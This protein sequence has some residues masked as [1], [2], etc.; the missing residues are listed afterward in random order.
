MKRRMVESCKQPTMVIILFLSL[1]LSTRAKPS[2]PNVLFIAV[3]DLKPSIGAFGDALAITPNLDQLAE[4]G[5]VFLNNHCQKAICGPSRA[6]LMSGMRPDTIRVWEFGQRMREINP[7]LLS[8]P[9]HFKNHGYVTTAIGK[10]YDPRNVNDQWDE[11]SWSIPHKSWSDFR[12][13]PAYRDV[14]NGQHH[15][16]RAKAVSAEAKAKGVVGYQAMRKYLFEEDVWAVTECLAEN[17]PDHAYVDGAI[18]LRAVEMLKELGASDTPFFLGVGFAKPHL[19]FVAPKKYWDLYDREKLRIHPFQT[20]SRYAVDM[21]YHTSG[22]LKSYSGIPSEMN[23]YADDPEKWLSEQK[24]L[25]LIHGYYACA[26]YV[27]AQIGK[28]MKALVESGL[29]DDTIVVVWGDHGFHL[30]DHGLWHKHT[31]FEQATRSPLL[32]VAPGFIKGAVDAPT[33]FID[34]FPTLC[35]L[36]GLPVPEQLDGIS[37][38]PA[39]KEPSFSVKP[40]AVSQYSYNGCMGYSIRTDRFRY[41]EWIQDWRT[42]DPYDPARVKGREL[43]DYDKD[44]C[45]TINRVDD[46]AY[47]RIRKGMERHLHAFF[48]EACRK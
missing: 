36:T 21:A 43:Y 11:E 42:F 41:T 14:V 10:I 16:E 19:P 27:D 8:L 12:F 26:S 1:A 40:F 2:L 31:N 6:S 29:S 33:E 18:A 25:E 4:V 39:M 34:L 35:E 45:E 46:S 23:S 15:S 37:L 38:V 44:P 9:E 7:D 47:K 3:D 20:K 30:G 22:E 32:M 24:Q 13:H 28:L 5:T 48:K 17:V